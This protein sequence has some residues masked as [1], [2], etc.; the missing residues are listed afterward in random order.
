MDA[1]NATP[2]AVVSI[3]FGLIIFIFNKIACLIKQ[4]EIVSKNINPSFS[5]YS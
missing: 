3:I 4:L 1:V 5:I 2:K